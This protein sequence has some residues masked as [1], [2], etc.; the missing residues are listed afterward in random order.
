[1]LHTLPV[2]DADKLSRPTSLSVAVLIPCYNEELAVAEVIAGFRASLP[3]A[4]MLVY[5]NNSSDRTRQIASTA[6]AVVRNETLQG[7]GHV[8][9]RMFAD[10][11]ADIY[12]LVDGDNTYDPAAA[13]VMLR[14]LLE[15]QLDMVTAVRLT[16]GQDAY[17]PGHRIGNRVLSFLVCRVF[18]NRVSDVLSGYRVFSRRFVKSFP[19]LATGFETETEFTIHALELKMPI[20]ELVTQYRGRATGSRSKLHTISDGLRILR[21]IMKLVKQERPLQSFGLTG[22]ALLL[23]RSRSRPTG[24]AAVSAQRHGAAAAHGTAGNRTGTG[25]VAVLRLR[26]RAG[27]GG[28]R[29]AGAEAAGLPVDPS[30]WQRPMTAR[31]IAGAAGPPPGEYDADVVILSFDRPEETLAAI[32]SALAQ[33]GVSRH[34]FIVDQGSRPENLAR[35]AAVVAGRQDATLVALDHNHGVAGGRNRGSALGHGRVIFGLDNDAEFADTTTLARAVAALDGDP[36]WPRSVAASCWASRTRTTCRPGAIRAAFCRVRA[37]HSTRS[38]SSA[39][40]T[41]SAAPHGTGYDEALFFC[42]EE[43]DFCLRAIER[44]WRIRYRGDI[45]VH[46]KVSPEQRVAWSGTRWF[47]FVRNRLYIERKWGAGWFGLLPRLAFYLLKGARNGVL[48][49]TCAPCL[50]RSVCHPA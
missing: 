36:T 45:A 5:D 25:F 22:A 15:N 50:R 34:V 27:T 31:H 8:V 29:A 6:G 43:F 44:G 32:N 46:H 13:P 28:A 14:Q 11:E 10:V 39:P 21:T 20:G 48:L 35:L 26:P 37:S 12:V 4:T 38:P 7:K 16:A 49:Q 9:R 19:A 3:D 47:H 1:M 33:T 40:D 24:R 23:D 18:G 2:R 17:R 41:R 42:W 30:D